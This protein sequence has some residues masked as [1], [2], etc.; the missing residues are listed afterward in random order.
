MVDPVDET[1]PPSNRRDNNELNNEADD[2]R[3]ARRQRTTIMQPSDDSL[4][5]SPIFLN[6][7]SEISLSSLEKKGAEKLNLNTKYIDLHLLRIITPVPR[8]TTAYVFNKN[9]KSNADNSITFYRIFLCRVHSEKFEQDNDRLVY[10]METRS[11]NKALWNQNVNDRDSGAIAIGSFIR[12]PVPM[13]VDSYMRGDIPLVNSYFPAMLLKLP[14]VLPTVQRNRGIEANTSLAFISNNATVNIH[15]TVPIKTSCTGNFCDK[16]QVFDWL[17]TRGCGCYG[18]SPNSTNL[19]FQH[20]LSVSNGTD[21][22]E[23]DNFSSSKFSKLYLK[24][25]IPGTIM[26]YMLKNAQFL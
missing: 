20:H 6:I 5:S 14:P 3:N 7:F 15:V 8:A 16:Q 19:V 13:P 22:Y 11:K 24:D 12:L 26:L 17:G 25:I 23:M 9:K 1:E 18:M 2:T 21:L 4:L 10:L